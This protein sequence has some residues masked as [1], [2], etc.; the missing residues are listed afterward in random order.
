MFKLGKFN[1][2]N[3]NLHKY[4]SDFLIE[5]SREGASFVVKSSGSTGQSKLIEI[6]KSQMKLSAQKT[7]QFFQFNSEPKALLCL[8]F[9]TIAGKMMLVRALVG[10]YFL[11][12]DSPS[13]NP[14]KKITEPIDFLAIVPLQLET[15][16]S[17]TPEKLNL[18]KTIIVGGAPV[19]DKLKQL[20]KEAKKTVFQTY[21]MTETVSHIALRKIGFEERD[22]YQALQGVTFTALEGNLEIHYPELLPQPLLTTDFVH[23]IDSTHFE[24]IGRTD[25]IINSGGVKLNPEA[26]ERKLTSLIDVPFFISS[27]PDDLLGNKLTFV[28]E[29][30]LDISM[31]KAD[32]EAL[33]TKYE[34]PKMF[35]II[36][37]FERTSSGKINRKAT[38]S[39]ILAND[40]KPIL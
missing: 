10:D 3:K 33:L 26:I 36:P 19:S 25:F 17:E 27:I 34:L 2:L 18:V 35:V 28:L 14:L 1:S 39:K 29:S 20:L 37:T 32:F 21:G 30:E 22:Y 9:D 11:Q 8:S 16:L 38:A 12:I 31:K 24:W 6:S 7:N 5:W 15:I 40:W 23:L 13:S 4:V